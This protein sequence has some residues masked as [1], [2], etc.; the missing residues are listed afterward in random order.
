MTFSP[1]Y[2]RLVLNENFEDAKALLLGPLLAIHA[3]HLAMLADTDMLTPADARAL[4]DALRGLD[5]AAIR[6]AAFT[7]E[8]EDLFFYVERLLSDAAG[9]DASSKFSLSTSRT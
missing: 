2:V 1:D 4:R 5:A 7:G 9:A 8:C 3:G 6:A